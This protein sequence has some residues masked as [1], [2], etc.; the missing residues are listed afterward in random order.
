VK[1]HSTNFGPYQHRQVRIIEFP[2]YETFAQS[3]P[4]TIPFSEG[5]GFVFG[6]DDEENIDHVFNVTAHEVAHQWWAHQVIGGNVQGATLMSEA[7]AEYSALMV[8]EKE[9]GRD[10]MRHML[11]YELDGHL[12]GRGTQRNR[13]AHSSGNQSVGCSETKDGNIFGRYAATLWCCAS[14]TRRSGVDHPG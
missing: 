9:Y 5:A 12:R 2:C 6:T 3:F 1:F 10:K 11:K 13:E 7:L 4:N 14:A 8:M